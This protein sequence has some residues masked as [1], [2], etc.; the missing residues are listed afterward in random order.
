MKA[1]FVSCVTILFCLLVV[2]VGTSFTQPN[3]ACD[4][5][6]GC[7]TECVNDPGVCAGNGPP[8]QFELDI[9]IIVDSCAPVPFG[10]GCVDNKNLPF[11][12]SWGCSDQFCDD[13]TCAIIRNVPQC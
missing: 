11:C 4:G 8:Y 2:F 3:W 13:V 10:P 6:P 9:Q 1:F 5:Y 12:N 7:N